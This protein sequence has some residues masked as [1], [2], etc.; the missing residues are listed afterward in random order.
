M[1][2]AY[3]DRFGYPLKAAEVARRL[4]SPKST[5]FYRNGVWVRRRPKKEPANDNAPAPRP[6]DTR[7]L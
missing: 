1:A 5:G 4:A 6:A 7:N 2:D 3:T